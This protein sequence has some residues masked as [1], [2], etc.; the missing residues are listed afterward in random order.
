M[1]LNKFEGPA[2]DFLADFPIGTIFHS[3]QLMEWMHS[4]ANGHAIGH[5]LLIDDPSKRLSAIRRHLNNGGASRAFSEDARFY[6]EVLDVIQQTYVVKRY[7]D[8]VRE[9]AMSA[10]DRSIS[11]AMT[12]YRRAK[13]TINSIKRADLTEEEQQA[14]DD[15]LREIVENAEPVRQLYSEQVIRHAVAALV[16]KGFD[17]EAARRLI[18]VWPSMARYQKLLKQTS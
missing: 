3:D 12:P 11:G 14:L 4:K 15:Q 8:Y 6:I 16:A 5:D 9:K 1:L 17:G 2:E 13:S 18:D 7:L 10:F